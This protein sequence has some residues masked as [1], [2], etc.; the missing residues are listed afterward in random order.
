M[1][2]LIAMAEAMRVSG[3]DYVHVVGEDYLVAFEDGIWLT[4]ATE[5]VS[6]GEWDRVMRV[7][8]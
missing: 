1:S 8:P 4:Q 2:K 5:S 6:L 3:Q 7:L